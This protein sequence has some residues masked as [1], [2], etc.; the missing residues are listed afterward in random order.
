ML[1]LRL[2]IGLRLGGLHVGHGVCVYY[3]STYYKA[4][5][6][7]G[8]A[9]LCTVTVCH[10]VFISAVPITK[11]FAYYVTDWFAA[12]CNRCTGRFVLIEFRATR[13]ARRLAVQFRAQSPRGN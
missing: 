10:G 4:V 8:G 6:V 2:G 3:C 11:L 7:G 13:R 9:E 5:R 12:G 1:W